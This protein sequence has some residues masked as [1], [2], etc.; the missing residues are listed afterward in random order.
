MAKLPSSD[1]S[2][3]VEEIVTTQIEPFQDYSKLAGYIRLSSDYTHFRAE[4]V[5]TKIYVFG[6]IRLARFIYAGG[7]TKTKITLPVLDLSQSSWR[8]IITA[9][10]G[11]EGAC[12]CLYDDGIFWYGSF[13][14]TGR[15]R[16]ELQCLFR[17]DLLSEE[18]RQV[19]YTGE[20]PGPRKHATS[21]YSE[22]RQEMIVFGGFRF[23]GIRFTQGKTND[24]YIL[25]LQKM[26]WRTP[27]ITGNRPSPREKHA[28]CLL[29]DILYVYGGQLL[30]A[31]PDHGVYLLHLQS[32]NY[33]RWS[34]PQ[35]NSA[36]L[37]SLSSLSM[38]PHG[39]LIF[40]CQG[41]PL[42]SSNLY[43]YDPVRERFSKV[44]RDEERPAI[45]HGHTAVSLGNERPTV[46]LGGSLAG[47]TTYHKVLI[48]KR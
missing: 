27:K 32:A 11:Q 21:N 5:G 13:I 37:G 4:L 42:T 41:G 34:H 20:D 3:R 14:D 33:A 47:F 45:S 35:T 8:W 25:S 36:A 15:N 48:A 19:Q 38:T 43:F 24:V 39:R 29:D 28:A 2:V 46:I 23:G 9:G 12:T 40:L 22:R 17:L 44:A 26:T 1:L 30:C 7:L 18:F 10:P 16:D 31:Q 6:K